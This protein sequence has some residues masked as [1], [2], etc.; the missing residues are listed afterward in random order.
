M[1]VNIDNIELGAGELE[2]FV[3]A[4]N[5]TLFWDSGI[6]WDTALQ[7]WPDG[8]DIGASMFG[9]YV[10]KYINKK[11]EIGQ[12]TAAVKN[13]KIGSEGSFKIQIAESSLANLLIAADSD[14]GDIVTTDSTQESYAFGGSF[15]NISFALRYTVKRLG[16]QTKRDVYEMFH[17]K[18]SGLEPIVIAKGEERSFEVTFDLLGE[19]NKDW[20]LSQLFSDKLS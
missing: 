20:C 17:A 16:D 15:A 10:G 18:A 5:N 13:A 4:S 11:L 12:V 3:Y 2:V 1:S 7:Y 14:P 6:Y 19:K 9:E 8:Y